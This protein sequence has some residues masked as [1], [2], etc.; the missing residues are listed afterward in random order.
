MPA[1]KYR[2]SAA[3][4]STLRS[5][6][7]PRSSTAARRPSIIAGETAFSLA[8]LV[9]VKVSTPLSSDRRK[10]VGG[11]L[12]VRAPVLLGRGRVP[13]LDQVDELRVRA[14]DQLEPLIG[15]GVVP[16]GDLGAH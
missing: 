15:V 9:K 6:R 13:R 3:I 12:H 14:D 11:A 2:P 1:V 5:S 16:P 10:G 7:S 4:T 8:S